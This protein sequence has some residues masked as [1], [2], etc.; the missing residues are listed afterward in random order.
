MVL[1]Q[2]EQAGAETA[3]DPLSAARRQI[4]DGARF[5]SASDEVVQLL[6]QPA[7]V[8]EVAIPVRRDD[9]SLEVFTGYRAQHC[10]VLGPAKGGIRFHPAVNVDEV[11]ALAMW[12]TIKCA[13]TDLPYG[14]GK[15]GVVCD[16]GSLSPGELERL[17]RGY[18]RALAPHIGPDRDIPA[19]DVGTSAQVM[20]WMVDEYAQ[21][22]GSFEPAA[23]TGK[24]LELGGIPGRA[25]ATGLGIFFAGREA[26]HDLGRSVPGTTVAV[27][28]FGKVGSYAAR[29]FAQGGARVVAVSDV[30]G[31]VYNPD[32]LD[33]EQLRLHV[34]RTGTVKGFA[35]GREIERDQLLLLPVD[36]LVPAA[37]EG[38]IHAGNAGAIQARLV[39]EGAN[40]PTTVEADEILAA[41]GITVVPDILANAGGVIVSYF[42]WAMNRS[43]LSWTAE[44][45]QRRLEAKMKTVYAEVADRARRINQPLR[46]AAYG[47]AID[48]LAGA[49][50]ARGWVK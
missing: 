16:P 23:F 34:D 35:G 45:V 14:G 25:E 48:R 15:G 32:G 5:S 28:G 19:P 2:S 46:P 41:R 21:I 43:R 10:D 18:V 39:V 20:A 42:E 4:I 29:Y 49:M 8:Y 40:G 26:L 3:A 33:I 36:V 24:P 22:T 9:G 7:R 38:Q 50:R 1:A 17:S 31:A 12:M 44:E 47:V 11:K 13:L 37:L 6:L 30:F 27:Q